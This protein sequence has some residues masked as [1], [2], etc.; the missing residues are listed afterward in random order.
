MFA[1]RAGAK[2]VIAVDAS[3]VVLKAKEIIKANNFED[4]ITYFLLAPGTLRPF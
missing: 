3:D 4:I 2:R 1:A